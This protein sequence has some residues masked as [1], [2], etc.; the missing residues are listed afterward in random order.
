MA[1]QVLVMK[2]GKVVEQGE[3]EA[4][5]KAPQQPYTQALL[6]AALDVV[7]EEPAAA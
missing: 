7:I 4:I 5:F 6:K 2:D 1:H 3:A